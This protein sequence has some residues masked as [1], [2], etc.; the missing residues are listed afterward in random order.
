[1]NIDIFH[2]REVSLDGHSFIIF[3][4]RVILVL[5]CTFFYYVFLLKYVIV[6]VIMCNNYCKLSI[7]IFMALRI[8]HI[9]RKLLFDVTKN[10]KNTAHR[11]RNSH[12]CSY[13]NE[14][15]TAILIIFRILPLSCQAC[16]MTCI[17]TASK[18]HFRII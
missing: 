17:G 2:L 15:D 13:F 4:D 18:C 6:V 11:L 5:R 12:I 3:L 10:N 14:N 7:L 1:M 9:W 16:C 8:W